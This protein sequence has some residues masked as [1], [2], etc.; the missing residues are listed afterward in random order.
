M[1]G[2]HVLI[3]KMSF[4]DGAAASQVKG[5]GSGLF[6][7]CF[8]VWRYLYLTAWDVRCSVLRLNPVPFGEELVERLW[9]GPTICLSHRLS[10]LRGE[11]SSLTNSVP[12]LFLELTPL[13]RL[14][15]HRNPPVLNPELYGGRERQH[16]SQHDGDLD[17][18]SAASLRLL[19][20]RGK[21]VLPLTGNYAHTH[22]HR[23]TQYPVN[24]KRNTQTVNWK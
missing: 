12:H 6:A 21:I 18:F 5:P 1:V 2:L 16:P 4:I 8:C 7:V 19:K 20:I 15:E 9:F 13:C 23:D 22:T 10:S 24:V 3:P 17:I 11:L 14:R